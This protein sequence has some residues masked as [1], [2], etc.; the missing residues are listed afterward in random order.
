MPRPARRAKPHLD[1]KP[2]IAAK[3]APFT[4]SS[5]SATSCLELGQW[6]S[7]SEAAE[8]AGTCSR[9]LKRRIAE[10]VLP[11]TRLPSPK[12]KGHL[13][14]RVGDIEALLARGRIK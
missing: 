1:T 3:D 2:T 8:R 12:G 10:G 9:T 14:I 5:G 11:A 13:R 6:L 7:A 4:A